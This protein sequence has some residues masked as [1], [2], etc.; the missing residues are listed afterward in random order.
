MLCPSH[1]LEG[2][3]VWKLQCGDDWCKLI[4]HSRNNK[5]Y[6]E[7]IEK[8]WEAS[9]IIIGPVSI[10]H[11]EVFQAMKGWEEVTENNVYTVG[12]QRQIVGTQHA[13]IGIRAMAALDEVVNDTSDLFKAW[14]GWNSNYLDVKHV[15]NPEQWVIDRLAIEK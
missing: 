7:D 11:N 5:C 12:A 15:H 14:K 2:P 9:K 6:P 10:N 4:W 1:I 8:K 3:S 13:W